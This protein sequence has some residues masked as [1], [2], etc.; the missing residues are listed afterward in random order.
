MR[1]KPFFQYHFLL[2]ISLFFVCKQALSQVKST[3]ST[4]ADTI[5]FIPLTNIKMNSEQLTGRV[6]QVTAG[7]K[8][9]TIIYEDGTTEIIT[10]RVIN[11]AVFPSIEVGLKDIETGCFHSLCLL[12]D[13][14]IVQYSLNQELDFFY[15]WKLNKV[16]E[17]AAGLRMSVAIKSN[18]IMYTWGLKDVV[19][20]Y[21]IPKKTYGVKTTSIGDDFVAFINIKNK[22]FVWGSQSNGKNDIPTFKAI[23]T[24]IASG[25]KHVLV[26]DI[27]GEL[28]CWGNGVTVP[29][30]L[31]NQKVVQ[32]DAKNDF[33]AVLTESNSV[34]VWNKEL[35]LAY[36]FLPLGKPV[37]VTLGEGFLVVSLVKSDKPS[38]TKMT[39]DDNV[40]VQKDA[41]KDSTRKEG[42][43][44]LEKYVNNFFEIAHDSLNEMEYESSNSTF[45]FKNSS[46]EYEFLGYGNSIKV[47]NDGVHLRGNNVKRKVIIKG[48]GKNV[49]IRQGNVNQDISGDTSTVYI[50]LDDY[51][52]N[53]YDVSYEVDEEA[54]EGQ[55]ELDFV[56]IDPDVF[57]NTT[58]T[59]FPVHSGYYYIGGYKFKE[60]DYSG[61]EENIAFV[62]IGVERSRGY[63][64]T[65]NVTEGMNT[66]LE[67]I[68]DGF[69]TS[70]L[71]GLFEV[72][73]YGLFKVPINLKKANYYYDLYNKQT[74]SN[75]D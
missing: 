37:D 43:M 9:A 45:D 10:D 4:L 25:S 61:I 3:K 60:D 1:T 46:I 72:Y 15:P 14:T 71:L 20:K 6:A 22:V 68:Q 41:N 70:C 66:L 16:R 44:N 27:K 18:N 31:K 21:K 39:F 51:E 62:G 75:W 56:E 24:A 53:A 40:F 64:Y 59:N 26:K 55:F 65:G 67:C 42:E 57:E 47:I 34:V 73:Y 12:K 54:N 48:S 13:S 8:H 63:F 38:V 29:L 23:P 19:S 35:V 32:I 50:D 58:L 5:V 49:V 7:Y 11:K 33:S 2:I 69:D 17:V 30:V 74:K 52:Q 28:Y 36:D